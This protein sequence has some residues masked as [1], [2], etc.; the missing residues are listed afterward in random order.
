MAG[1][2]P[3]GGQF[4]NL[5]E[6]AALSQKR[7]LLKEQMEQARALG[8]PSGRKF[9]TWGG[10]LAGG[11]GDILGGIAGQTK[12]ARL[13]EELGKNRTAEQDIM[14]GYNAALADASKDPDK[15]RQIA[16]QGISTGH[17]AL[18]ATGRAALESENLMLTRAREAERDKL[19][20]KEAEATAEFRKRQLANEEKRLGQ[21]AWKE[22]KTD[23][24]LFEMN[25]RTGELRPLLGPD[26]APLK[27]E[28]SQFS[29]LGQDRLI[30]K[31]AENMTKSLDPSQWGGAVKN[32]VIARDQ[33]QHILGLAEKSNGLGYNNL[34][35]REMIEL[36]AGF[37]RLVKGGTPT[38][39]EA[40]SLVPPKNLQA[41]V[42]GIKEWLFNE[43]KGRDQ[44]KFVEKM[45]H[46]VQRQREIA[47]NIIAG[48]KA[49]R[50]NAFQRLKKLD[51]D[52]WSAVLQGADMDPGN[53]DE[54]GVY[55]QPAPASGAPPSA[56]APAV[57]P[58]QIKARQVAR[59]AQLKAQGMDPAKIRQ[60]LA[61]E[62]LVQ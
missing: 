39:H 5:S 29:M 55:R 18:T 10:A 14:G 35:E 60:T 25:S 28:P 26:K 9:A 16:L 12:E 59:I 50:V 11:L 40:A 56:A 21:E 7:D 27:G 8:Q 17:P 20:L 41:G 49:Q 61:A 38:Q 24:G 32:Q 51:P 23:Q 43:P 53:F 30:A 3:S 31:L 45:A 1:E 62:G 48:T 19:A 42:A 58:E 52:Q 4:V 36:A 15:L 33:A 47:E 6:L 44:L 13:A 2:A 22:V 54:Q 34:D 46:S 37:A 57:P